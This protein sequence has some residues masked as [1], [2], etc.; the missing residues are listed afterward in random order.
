MTSQDWATIA[1]LVTAG[2]T[3]VLAIATFLAV[4]SGNRTARAAERSLAV[5]LRPLLLPSR[6]EDPVQKVG[7]ADN[8]WVKLPGSGGAAEVTEDAVYLAMSLRN[9]GS[10][11]AILH[12]WTFLND[13]P[14]ADPNHSS[15]DAFHR[16]TRDIYVAAGDLGFWQGAVRD[17]NSREFT[18]L[19]E[20]IEARRRLVF[21]LL[22]GDH[23]GGQ[24]VISLFS[25]VARDDGGWLVSVARHWN[26]DGADPR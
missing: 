3:L 22:Y 8:H 4:R 12:G 13:R 10:G 20:A 25:M 14:P 2:T 11:I 19:K 18:E 21:E 23:E 1:S 17:S 7:F 26:V 6:L 16:L 5:S 24:R 15:L 9:G